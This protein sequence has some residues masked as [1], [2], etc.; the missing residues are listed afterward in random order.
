MFYSRGTSWCALWSGISGHSS[1]SPPR[2]CTKIPDGGF[3][4]AGYLLQ[5]VDWYCEEV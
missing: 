5:P 2:A 3:R 1:G 4:V